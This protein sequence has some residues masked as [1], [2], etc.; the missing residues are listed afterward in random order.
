MINFKN[1]K[2]YIGLIS[3][4]RKINMTKKNKTMLDQVEEINE[5]NFMD[6]LKSNDQLKKV[7]LKARNITKNLSNVVVPQMASAIKM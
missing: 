4:N 2:N 6:N 5:T 7:L 3:N 1:I